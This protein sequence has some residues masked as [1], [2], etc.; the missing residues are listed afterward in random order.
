MRVMSKKKNNPH[1]SS[2]TCAAY[3]Q[4]VE[5]RFT[6]LHALIDEKFRSLHRTIYVGVTVS[7]LVIAVVQFLLNLK[8]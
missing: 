4:G 6:D 3:R 7:T 5:Q 1:V 8:G 2:E